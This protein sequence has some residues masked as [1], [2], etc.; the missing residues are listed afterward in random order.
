MFPNQIRMGQWVCDSGFLLLFSSYY[1]FG[2]KCVFIAALCMVLLWKLIDFFLCLY[3]LSSPSLCIGMCVGST[4]API[5]SPENCVS[6]SATFNMCATAHWCAVNSLLVCHG[7]V[8]E[9]H[10]LVEPLWDVSLPPAVRC[11][12]SVV[13]NLMV[14]FGGV[15]WD[16]KRLTL[17][18][19]STPQN[20]NSR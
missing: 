10:S 17:A 7:S 1:P 18:V 6:R 11:A 3:C 2:S 16:E 13:K 15:P 8:G 20:G 12:F 9:G 5:P 19:V 4:V 14:C